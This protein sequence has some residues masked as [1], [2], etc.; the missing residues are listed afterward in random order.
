MPAGDVD[1]GRCCGAAPFFWHLRCWLGTALRNRERPTQTK[2]A[3][4]GAVSVRRF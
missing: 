3:P 4:E 1:Q 2:T